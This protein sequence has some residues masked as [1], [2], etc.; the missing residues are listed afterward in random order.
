MKKQTNNNTKKSK[1]AEQA[2]RMIAGRAQ[3]EIY[4][5]RE[6]INPMSLKDIEK[7]LNTKAM[8]KVKITVDRLTDQ[9]EFFAE[10]DE[11][12]LTTEWTVKEMEDY[13]NVTQDM[14]RKKQQ[15]NEQ[16]YLDNQKSMT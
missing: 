2:S 10:Y 11:V 1:S 4:D 8:F 5:F 16:E 15:R 12:S 7:V 3:E 9:G 13:L 6:K 14:F